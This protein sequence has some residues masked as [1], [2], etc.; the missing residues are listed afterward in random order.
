M[1]HSLITGD[2]FFAVVLAAWWQ[3]RRSAYLLPHLRRSPSSL[4]VNPGHGFVSWIMAVTTLQ[5][6][7]TLHRRR[8][9]TRQMA[10]DNSCVSG[11]VVRSPGV[12]DRTHAPAARPELK[13][14]PA[15]LGP[16]ESRWATAPIPIPTGLRLTPPRA[17]RSTPRSTSRPAPD[18]PT[19]PFP[20]V[21]PRESEQATSPVGVQAG[22]PHA[23]DGPGYVEPP[24]RPQQPAVARRGAA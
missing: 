19:C 6:L 18:P 1:A 12:P 13:S 3:L 20:V 9:P 11:H 10:A 4:F 22:P 8:R 7:L 14:D 2:G 24:T 17:P 5:P 15:S 23:E 16:G 21:G